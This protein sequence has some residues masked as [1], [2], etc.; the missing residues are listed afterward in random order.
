VSSFST[1]ASGS[2]SHVERYSK[3]GGEVTLKA[4]DW[5]CPQCERHN[6]VRFGYHKC[7]N[8]EH[9][10][11]VETCLVQ[12]KGDIKPR[13]PR[14]KI[15]FKQPETGKKLWTGDWLCHGCGGINFG[16]TTDYKS[17]QHCAVAFDASKTFVV[18]A[19]PNRPTIAPALPPVMTYLKPKLGIIEDLKVRPLEA[20]KYKNSLVGVVSSTK[21]SKTLVVKVASTKTVPKYNV[22]IAVTKKYYAHDEREDCVEN[23]TVRIVPDR[24]RSRTKRWRVA[25]IID[26][27]K[28]VEFL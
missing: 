6:Y 19:Q 25:E 8:C 26:R 11:D 27:K 13:R 5:T 16:K 18:P 10:F 9:P 28:V 14:N 12:P 17:C 2:S 22:D 1:T 21:M 20:A 4:G 24:P 23:D 15:V 7:V 3:A